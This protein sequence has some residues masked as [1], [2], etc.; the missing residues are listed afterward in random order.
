MFV[1][2]TKKKVEVIHVAKNVFLRMENKR[3]R[4]VYE[5]IKEKNKGAGCQKTVTNV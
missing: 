1:L 3:V 4:F 2:G 5:H